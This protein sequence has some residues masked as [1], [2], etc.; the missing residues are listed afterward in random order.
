[1][2][3]IYFAVLTPFGLVRRTFGRSPLHRSRSSPTFWM[4]RPSG[5]SDL[6]RQF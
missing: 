6:E 1:M 5:R 4:A 2:G 3:I